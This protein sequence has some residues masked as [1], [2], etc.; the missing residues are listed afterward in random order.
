[1]CF[2]LLIETNPEKAGF[3]MALWATLILPILAFRRL[4]EIIESVV[5]SIAIYVVDMAIRPNA[6]DVKPRKP[7]RPIEMSIY[8]DDDIARIFFER[9]GEPS[10]ATRRAL[11]GHKASFVSKN[12]GFWVVIQNRKESFLGKIH[13][14]HCRTSFAIVVRGL[15]GVSALTGPWHFSTG[16]MYGR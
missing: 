16:N 2:V 14:S 1:M 11:L 15:V 4:A 3:V 13:G 10:S 8:P 6:F 7:V 12:A 9:S 5:A